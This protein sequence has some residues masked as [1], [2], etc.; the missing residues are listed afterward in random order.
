[1]KFKPSISNNK[2]LKT[3]FLNQVNSVIYKLE[4]GKRN[5]KFD[6]N[7][8]KNIVD[9]LNFSM[10][11][12]ES[13][14]GTGEENISLIYE[15]GII[16][17]KTFEKSLQQDL[18]TSVEEAC[19]ELLYSIDLWSD[20]LS[21][22]VFVDSLND[23]SSKLSFSKKRLLER[24]LELEK[25][26][27]DFFDNSN[28]LEKEILSIEKNVEELDSLILEENN[29]RKINDLYL[30]VS[31]FNSKK[32]YLYIRK[33]NYSSCYNLLDV[34]YS[35]A[36]EMMNASNYSNV[37]LSKI[38]AFLNLDKLSCVMNDPEK[39][40]LILNGMEKDIQSIKQKNLSIDSKFL[41]MKN[42]STQIS[43]EALSYK[44]LLMKKKRD[45]E[46]ANNVLNDD[47][48]VSK[49]QTVEEE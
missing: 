46:L 14:I 7:S 10:E 22:R 20:V 12:L 37:E 9:T 11:K 4:K 45:K 2:K 25:I 40:M 3:D 26:K 24:L 48:I 31:A 15:N 38:K 36:K 28:R 35:N 27:Q 44:E 6:D 42:D 13:S 17:L 47:I 32:D 49:K 29:E 18:F 16:A 30:Q 41:N 33:S 1:M 39:A 19:D 5:I 43:K 21:G 34:I 8:I 23:K